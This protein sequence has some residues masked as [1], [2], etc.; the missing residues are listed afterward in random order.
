[1][2]GSTIVCFLFPVTILYL[3]FSSF[4]FN[5]IASAGVFIAVKDFFLSAS[6]LPVMFV[7]S[8]NTGN[9]MYL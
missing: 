3:V 9:S 7:S 4:A 8:A 1:M 5:R 6:D 2:Y